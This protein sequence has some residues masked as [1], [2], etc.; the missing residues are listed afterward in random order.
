MQGLTKAEW[1]EVKE[2][3]IS[4]TRTMESGGNGVRAL[5]D[6]FECGFEGRL[7]AQWEKVLEL[8]RDPEYKRYREA[9][10]KYRRMED[11]IRSGVLVGYPAI[12]MQSDAKKPVAV[13]ER[14]DAAAE[15]D[16]ADEPP[17]RKPAT[18][19]TR[20]VTRVTRNVHT[21]E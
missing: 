13:V 1:I 12:V 18:R 6:V 20:R 4:V 10:A 14:T 2:H 7:P 9:A 5:L 15:E 8:V 11:G 16:D 3:L 19:N 17:R 21:L